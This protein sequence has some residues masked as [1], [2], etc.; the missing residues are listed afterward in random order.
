MKIKGNLNKRKRKGP[1]KEVRV[2]E[3]FQAFGCIVFEEI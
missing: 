2:I 3:D 1:V